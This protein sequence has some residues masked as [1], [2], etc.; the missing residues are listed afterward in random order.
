MTV[1]CHDSSIIEVG[2][3]KRVESSIRSWLSEYHNSSFRS[4]IF[5]P[6]DCADE[7]SVATKFQ[8]KAKSLGSRNRKATRQSPQI[9]LHC[10]QYVPP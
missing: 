10:T 9:L 2:E 4:Q 6:Q 7:G 5:K 8:Q 3:V 1:T